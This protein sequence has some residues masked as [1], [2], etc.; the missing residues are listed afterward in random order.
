MPIA[1]HHLL[2]LQDVKNLHPPSEWHGILV[3]NFHVTT[4]FLYCLL[5]APTLKTQILK[6]KVPQQRKAYNPSKYHNPTIPST[7]KTLNSLRQRSEAYNLFQ[8]YI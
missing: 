2:L 1:P 5:I 7:T 8:K 3:K 6:R 4:T